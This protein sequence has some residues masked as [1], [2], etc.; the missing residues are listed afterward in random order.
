MHHNA[1]ILFPKNAYHIGTT[2]RTTA[3]QCFLKCIIEYEILMLSVISLYEI[4]MFVT[5]ISTTN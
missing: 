1:F 5:S 3:L 2:S 4:L